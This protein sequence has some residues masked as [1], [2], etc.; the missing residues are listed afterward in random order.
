MAK[1]NCV[2]LSVKEGMLEKLN[3]LTHEE[4]DALSSANSIYIYRSTYTKKVY[5]GQT[6]QF[7]ERHK[8][9]FNGN[10]KKFF[11]SLS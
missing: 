8:Q 9:H 11:R 10:E 5:I 7:L 2:E 1:Y 6:K 4:L 3:Q